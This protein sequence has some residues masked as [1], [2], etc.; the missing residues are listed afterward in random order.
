MIQLGEILISEEVFSNEFVCNI[1]K[2]KGACCVEG[3]LGAPLTEDELGIVDDVYDEVEPYLDS[4]AKEEVKKQGRYVM[5]WED[6]FSTPT[7][8]GKECVYAVYDEGGTLHCAFE[9]A[10]NDGKIPFKKPISCHLYPIRAIKLAS[11]EAVNYDRWNICADACTLGK[12][13]RVPIYKFLKD[14]LIRKYGEDWYKELELV[15]EDFLDQ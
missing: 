15:A 1:S 10:Y 6:E 3:D 4:I 14:P 13:L 9:Q 11:G 8:D 7:V 2:C 5:D 12:E